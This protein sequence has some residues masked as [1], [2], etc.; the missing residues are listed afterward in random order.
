MNISILRQ[1][2]E[3]ND[4]Q[5]IIQLASKDHENA[6]QSND[7]LPGAEFLLLKAAAMAASDVL[8]SAKQDL[9][10]YRKSDL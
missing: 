3:Y 9:E 1:A 5:A 2:I 4:F 10:K 6:I 8:R 7:L